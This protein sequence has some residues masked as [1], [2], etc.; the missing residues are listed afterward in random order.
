MTDKN[1][2]TA[3]TG[4]GNTRVETGDLSFN[5]VMAQAKAYAKENTSQWEEW[6]ASFNEDTG[7]IEMQVKARSKYG[8]D[9]NTEWHPVK[10]GNPKNNPITKFNEM[11]KVSQG[12][13]TDGYF[14]KT[15]AGE[16]VWRKGGET[17][18][19]DGN[20]MTQGQLNQ[21]AIDARKA[22]TANQND[23]TRKAYNDALAAK[24]AGPGS[25]G[26]LGDDGPM[27]GGDDNPY[28]E[29]QVVA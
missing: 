10:F 3:A 6:K 13:P 20:N 22:Y 27:T 25:G 17:K 5:D 26:N 4:P 7:E 23:E 21:A 12:L 14:E 8:P 28:G 19:G 15:S 16:Y 9:A 18:V 24:K 29:T 11:M 2:Q 1:W